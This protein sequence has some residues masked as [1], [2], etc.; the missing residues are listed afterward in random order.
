MA[1]LSNINNKFLVT[2]TGEVLIGQTAN[3]G[4]RL[5]ITGADGASYIYLKT[6]V[7][8][9]GGRIGFN[10]DDLRV[11]NQQAGGNLSFGTV[12]TE[13]MKI[14]QFAQIFAFGQMRLE[15]AAT[16][17]NP[18]VGTNC[19]FMFQNTSNTDGNLAVVDFRNSTGF[20]TG[21]IGAQFQDAGDRNTDLF[22]MTRA[23][24]GS[25]TERMRIESGG[26][27]KVNFNESGSYGNLYFQDVDNGASMFYIQP[28]EYK[29]STPYNTNY[30]NA[31][32][33]S[34]IGF[35]AGGSER[36]H[37]TSTGFLQVVDGAVTLNK[38]DGS[39]ITF[40]YNGSTKGYIG[41]ER[42]VVTGGS[43]DN[44]AFSS[45]AELSFAT[46]SSLTKRMNIT[47]AGNVGIGTSSP[48]DYDG[49]SD[50]LVVFNSTTPGITIATD[51]TAS[52]G[53]LRFAD[54]TSGNERY[55][56]GLEYDHNT[57]LMIFRTLGV[58][59][60]TL[61]DGGRLHPTG[62]VFLG[63][64]NNSNLLN[65]YEEGTWT[66]AVAMSGSTV[67]ATYSY[68]VG[69]YIKIGKMVMAMWDLQATVTG[70]IS[71]F[72]KIDNLPFTVG[73]GTPSGT[74]AG[75]SVAQ[76]RSSSLFNLAAA[77][78][79]IK[80]FPNQNTTYV[81]CQLDGSGTIGFGGGAGATWKTGVLGR[82]TGYTMYFVN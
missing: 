12:G 63:S 51:N 64:S 44:M 71:G 34:N 18:I 2:T 73:S 3:D 45:L 32:N 29:G 52:R 11:F 17:T 20:V 33:S 65:D 49:E 58:Q 35:I 38:S 68:R 22:F 40:N 81:Y 67:S 21:R 75:Y 78:Q 54:G 48:G 23:N 41:S 80:G 42:Q 31:A 74:M 55:R 59:Q 57:D 61:Y 69:S 19:A 10:S 70:S 15:L 1:N 28:A 50:D 25:L 5:Q 77:E 4:N 9:T 16:E 46:G 14:D 43:Q 24:G 47:S 7:A 79:Q 8:T 53:A 66:P 37:I 26:N 30:L 60:M 62:G 56:G 82:A 76:W 13:R 27:I 6:D 39:Y 36:I 72:A